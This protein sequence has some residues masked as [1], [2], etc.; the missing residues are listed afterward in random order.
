MSDFLTSDLAVTLAVYLAGFLTLGIVWGSKAL[1]VSFKAS[2]N[3]V[4]DTLIP[5]LEKIAAALETKEE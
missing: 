3:K 5:L 1:I 4:D 2:S